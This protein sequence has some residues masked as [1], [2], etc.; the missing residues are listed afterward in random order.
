M[1]VKI[2]L[3]SC[4]AVMA[5]AAPRPD[6]SPYHPPA[7]TYHEPAPYKPYQP[8]PEYPAEPPKYEYT[9][10]VN[11]HYSG[12]NFEASENRDGYLTQGSYSVILP[13]TRKQAVTYVDNGDGLEAVVTYEGEAVFPEYKPEYK[14]APYKSAPYKPAPYKPAPYHA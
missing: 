7:P 10:G 13:D 2:V 12:A 5:L 14:P 3:L 1:A 4:V 11:D 8:E 6:N 9:Y